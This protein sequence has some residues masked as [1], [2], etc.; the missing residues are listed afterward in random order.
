MALLGGGK[1]HLASALGLV[2]AQHRFFIYYVNCHQL[3][4]QLKRAHFENRLPDKL[5]VL[6]K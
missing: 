2:A 4:E 5:R 1:T 6:A 3:V